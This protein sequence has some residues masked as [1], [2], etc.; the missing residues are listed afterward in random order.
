[1][2]SL[3]ITRTINAPVKKVFQAVADIHQFSQAIPHIVRVE[4]VAGKK[5]AV[6]TR[7][8]ETRSTKGKET[9]TELEITEY[10][11]NERVRLVADSHG[12]VWDSVFRVAQAAGGTE[13]TLTM[14]AR[15]HQLLP[16]LLNPLV[17]GMIRKAVA[18]DLDAVKAWCEG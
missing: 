13:L 7:F 14:E 9:T 2:P 18:A 12:T 15:A 1:M 10:A 16:R 17:M 4:M 3:T 8:R 6:G 11:E 5:P